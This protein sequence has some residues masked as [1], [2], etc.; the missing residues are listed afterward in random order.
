MVLG[1]L[2]IAQTQVTGWT[3]TDCLWLTIGESCARDFQDLQ[4]G[5]D[6]P[7]SAL[8][9]RES[10]V[11]RGYSTSP[12]AISSKPSKMHCLIALYR[13]HF[14]VWLSGLASE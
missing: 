3:T 13:W 11:E 7:S 5:T 9:Q 4:Q 14:P 8:N 12:N 1:R 2:M 6:N 10:H